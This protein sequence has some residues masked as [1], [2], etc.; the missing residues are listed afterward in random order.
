MSNPY[1][2]DSLSAIKQY[3]VKLGS[4]MGARS[5]GLYKAGEELMLQPGPEARTLEYAVQDGQSSLPSLH[6]SNVQAPISNPSAQKRTMYYQAY[7]LGYSYDEANTDFAMLDVR[8]MHSAS[9]INSYG[10]LEDVLTL[11]ALTGSSYVSF[12]GGAPVEV[13]FPPANTIAS[14]GTSYDSA[15]ELA[16]LDWCGEH[17]WEDADVDPRICLISDTQLAKF[18]NESGN[19]KDYRPVAEVDSWEMGYGNMGR[20]EKIRNIYYQVIPNRYLD[21]YGL[22]TTETACIFFSRS[23]LKYKKGRLVAKPGAIINASDVS[24]LFQYNFGASRQY[25]NNVVV[26]QLKK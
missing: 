24:M 25:E 21:P 14:G 22:D 5:Q 11:S 7:D 20:V 6:V 3:G 23:A 4:L 18:K 19:S 10:L 12:G 8:Q 15:K 13:P 2:I 26:Q 9:I 17:D 16:F 1:G